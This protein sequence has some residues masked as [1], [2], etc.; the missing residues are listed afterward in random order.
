M[1]FDSSSSKEITLKSTPRTIQAKYGIE[2]ETIQSFDIIE[3]D[4]RGYK[5]YAFFEDGVRKF[6]PSRTY[7]TEDTVTKTYNS[8]EEARSYI[9][10]AAE[11]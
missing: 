7:L 2:Y 11:K 8:E 10:S 9:D 5:I 3:N 4:Y 6:I 1:Y